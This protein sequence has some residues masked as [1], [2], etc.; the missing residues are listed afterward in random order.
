MSEVM[1]FYLG[2]AGI[3]GMLI[4]LVLIEHDCQK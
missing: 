3:V 2:L 1:I 4:G